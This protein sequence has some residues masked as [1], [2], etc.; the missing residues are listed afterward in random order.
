MYNLHRFLIDY[1]MAMLRALAESRGVRLTTNR[2]TG[3]ADQLAALL[4]DPLSVRTAL[5]RLSPQSR[6]AL[7]ALVAAGGQMRVPRFSRHF[8]QVRPIGP[9]R[10]ERDAPWRAPA[11]P[12]EELLY[13]GFIFRAF[14]HDE[15]GPGEFIFV[16]VDLRPLLPQPQVKPPTFA[17]EPAPPPPR[18]DP[19]DMALVHDLFGYLVYLQTHDV[20]PYADG[21]L[22]QRDLA[23][24]S[25]RLH[26][27]DARRLAFLRHLAG[28]LGLVV[29]QGEYLRLEAASA[30][31]WLTATSADQLAALQGAWRDDPTWNDLDRVPTL[32]C[33]QTP[34]WRNDPQATRQVLLALLAHCPLDGWWTLSSFVAAV[35][36]IHPDFQRPDGDYSRW[37]IRDAASGEYLSGFAAWDR[38]EGALIA[39]LLAGPLHW[40]GVVAAVTTATGTICCLTE[41]GARFLGLSAGNPAEPPSPPIIVQPDFSVQ[42]PSPANLY[43]CFQ[44]ERFAEP[45]STPSS[46]QGPE[47]LEPR[48]YRLTGGSLGRAL[49]RGL[50][51]EQVLAFLQRASGR[52]VPANV[53]G[54]LRL[55]AGRF[56]QV[57]LEE[58]V[59]LRVKSEQVLK[60]L[61]MLPQT[62]SLIA[63]VLSPTSALVRRQDLP[64]LQKELRVLG[65]LP[66]DEADGD[67]PE[68][69]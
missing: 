23:A 42:V 32:V 14:S 1:D 25:E 24:L 31:R 68:H 36:Q 60:E 64:R 50:Q 67:Y 43:T 62:R 59:L 37:Y 38:V 44:L 16:P 26:D 3:A 49:A 29:R 28:R 12:A 11:N 9:G 63:K 56:G 13:A 22:G 53:V 54:Q 19:S 46:G 4:L 6:E 61:S 2:Q 27:A 33:D 55:W 7:A 30:K 8:G 15:A 51:V 47:D 21:R 58:V 66:P 18:R 20:R 35:K 39:D 57:H 48:G 17:V 41:A 69:G 52:P 65:Y 34:P 40:L 5:A 10:L 45:C